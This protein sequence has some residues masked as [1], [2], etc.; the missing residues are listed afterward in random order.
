VSE[1]INTPLRPIEW[2]AGFLGVSKWAAYEAVK[3]RQI[4][5]G[6]VVR[7]GRRLRVNEELVRAWAANQLPAEAL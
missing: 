3:S 5:A 7:L 6:C 1:K 2:L 4:P